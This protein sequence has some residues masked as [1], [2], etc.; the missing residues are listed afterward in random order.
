MKEGQQPSERITRPIFER[1][2]VHPGV[3]DD[4]VSWSTGSHYKGSVALRD[5]IAAMAPKSAINFGI[6]TGGLEVRGVYELTKEE[7]KDVVCARVGRTQK[8]IVLATPGG[9][10]FTLQETVDEVRTGTRFGEEVLDAHRAEISLMQ[11]LA[12]RG[13]LYPA[14]PKPDGRTIMDAL[15]ESLGYGTVVPPTPVNTYTI[16]AGTI[17]RHQGT[18]PVIDDDEDL[19]R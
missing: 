11:S 13:E 16:H 19:P 4:V 5:Y 7:L 14:K 12:I 8:D 6:S 17:T 18:L 1:L 2:E 10:S 9:P 15:R 3:L